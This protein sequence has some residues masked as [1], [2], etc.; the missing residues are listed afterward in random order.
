MIPVRRSRFTLPGVLAAIERV[1]RGSDIQ[2]GVA[3]H[4]AVGLTRLGGGTAIVATHHWDFSLNRPGVPPS[5]D[6]FA[7]EQ[8]K[9][10]IRLSVMLPGTALFHVDG[11]QV[12]TIFDE[13]QEFLVASIAVPRNIARKFPRESEF[14]CRWVA[15]HFGLGIGYPP[16]TPL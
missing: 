8:V 4:G 11:E 16:A 6:F 5:R 2:I 10:I 9:Q 1:G 14:A 7:V 12:D 3:Q 13:M 15:H